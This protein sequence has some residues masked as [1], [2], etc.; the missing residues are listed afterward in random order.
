MTETTTELQPPRLVLEDESQRLL[1][2]DART[3]N[4][5]SDDPVDDEQL[6]A[7]YDLM[8]WAPTGGNAQPLRILF[9]RS[10]EAKERLIAHLNEGNRDKSR[11]A[12]VV[13]V[14]AAD[15]S[16]HE[17][18]G[19]LFPQRPQ[20][21]EYLAADDALRERQ[22]KFNAT[23]QAGYFILAVRAMG[24]AAGPMAGFDAAGVDKEFF[25]DGT[26]SSI[27]VVN[28]GRPGPEAWRDRLPRLDYHEAVRLA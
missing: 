1:F 22:A 15:T 26:W 28:I 25:A 18:M 5:F 4:T 9:I 17:H 24:L 7:I 14:L 2:T 19:R 21:K 10:P 11:S 23:L 12:P 6:A 20:M 8:K 27:L 16:F 3:A 13:A